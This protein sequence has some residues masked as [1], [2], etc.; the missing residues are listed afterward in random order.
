MFKKSAIALVLAVSTAGAYAAPYIEVGDSGDLLG[1]AQAIG[2]A[3]G[4]SG[5][6]DPGSDVDLFSF[7]WSG[8]VLTMDTF[9]T[10][11]DTQLHLFDSAG[12]GIGENDDSG[13]LQSE[14]SLNLAAGTYY[15]GITAFNNDALDAA[16][17]DIF[18]FTNQFS[19]LNGNTIQGP[20]AGAGALA[21]W[22]LST[23]SGGGG[24]TINFSATTD[25]PA[26][27]EPASLALL[28]LGLV[29]FA[30]ARRRKA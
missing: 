11:F 21:G 5:S 15:L 10:A 9:G 4:I 12:F 19:D 29:G 24:Y 13:S 22:N 26:V 18:G 17:N 20:E 3:D 6:I 27:S 14:I 2:A 16:N 28:G 30:A 8:G 25:A 23:G 1:T 7:L